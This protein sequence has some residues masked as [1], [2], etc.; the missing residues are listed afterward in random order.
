MSFLAGYE[1][2]ND[3]IIRFWK[4]FPT[5]RLVARIVEFNAEKGY[6]VIEAMAFRNYEDEKPSAIDY[7]CEF[8]SDRG[9]NLHFWVEN[10]VTSAYGRV[11]GLLTPST[12]R[13]TAED[14]DK[15]ER[16]QANDRLPAPRV[17][18]SAWNNFPS[19]KTREE[20]EAAGMP[21]LGT[22]IQ[23]IENK[24]GGILMQE[25]PQCRHGHMILKEGTSDKT[26][27]AYR[28]YVCMEKVK[29]RQCDAIWYIRTSTGWV[30]P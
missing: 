7:G 23:Q 17:D 13:S 11:I 6:V 8:K 19:F 29:S 2:V 20:A 3:R 9:V 22:A 28:G 30:K 10:A 16:L 25:A 4:E 14:M 5:G 12:T 15:V 1:I 24:F 18:E 21:T 27:K 26:G